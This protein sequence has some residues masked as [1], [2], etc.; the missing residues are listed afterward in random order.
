MSDT[1]PTVVIVRNGH[2]VVINMS[3]YNP[4]N[5]KLAG[6]K[7]EMIDDTS[8]DESKSRRRRN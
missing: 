6:E 7:K 8:H 2:N 5:D 1:V 3:D 4:D